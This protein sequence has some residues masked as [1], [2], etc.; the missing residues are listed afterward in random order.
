MESIHPNDIPT[1]NIE[2]ISFI[3]LKNG[4]MLMVDTS[5]PEKPK[6]KIQQNKKYINSNLFLISEHLT[7]TYKSVKQKKRKSRKSNNDEDDNSNIK[8]V[9]VKTD[10]NF[11][12]HIDKII[13][14][15]YKGRQ[16]KN[17]SLNIPDIFSDKESSNGKNIEKLSKISE[18]SKKFEKFYSPPSQTEESIINNENKNILNR[19]NDEIGERIRRKSRNFVGRFSTIL[20]DKNKPNAVISMNIPSDFPYEIS[21][22]QKKFNMLVTQLRQRQSKYKN[23]LGG[24]NSYQ[25]YYENFKCNKGNNFNDFQRKNRIKYY[26]ESE[27]EN[28]G[29]NLINLDNEKYQGNSINI[30]SSSLLG[31]LSNDITT[32]T[33]TKSI[34]HKSFNYRNNSI[35]NKKR[36]V[37]EGLGN[38]VRSSSDI[39]NVRIKLYTNK[40]GL[41]YPTNMFLK[42][43]SLDNSNN[44]F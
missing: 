30:N 28:L 14:F 23:Y 7:I 43:L 9:I 1:I 34:L 40:D 3:T 2:T 21:D 38:K 16:K 44:Y 11:V 27:A 24:F 36:T 33:S 22:T 35:I 31:K 41:V 29:K 5:V 19:E 32:I 20:G 39:K 18:K 6:S 10:F 17:L 37:T 15:F 12:S 4:K 13:D 42:R 25:K 8:K 26:Q